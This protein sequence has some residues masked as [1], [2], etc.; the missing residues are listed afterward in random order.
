MD[1]WMEIIFLFISTVANQATQI[2]EIQ[3]NKLRKYF[4]LIDK[5]KWTNQTEPS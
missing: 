1:G 4:S 5:Y 3:E 2:D